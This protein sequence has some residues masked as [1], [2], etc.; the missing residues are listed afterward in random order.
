MV[1]CL[2]VGDWPIADVAQPVSGKGRLA[3]NEPRSDG[4]GP[5]HGVA[6]VR[7]FSKIAVALADTSSYEDRSNAKRIDSRSFP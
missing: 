7:T 3:D 5:S 6:P 2:R 4:Q 1:R